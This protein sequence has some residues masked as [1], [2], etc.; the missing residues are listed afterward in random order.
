MH[1][2][3]RHRVTEFQKVLNRA[4][5]EV[6]TGERRT[7]TY[8]PCLGPAMAILISPGAVAERWC[9]DEKAGVDRQA[10]GCIPVPESKLNGMH[11]PEPGA[12]SAAA[13]WEADSESGRV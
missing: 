4:K 7:V 2:R 5:T 9:L 12:I 10:A 13:A 11:E 3:M 1:S 6:A 8:V